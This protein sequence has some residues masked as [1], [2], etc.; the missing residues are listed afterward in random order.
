MNVSSGTPNTKPSFDTQSPDLATSS[1]MG[2]CVVAT[3]LSSL[4]GGLL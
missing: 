1:Q 4:L 3:A 2:A